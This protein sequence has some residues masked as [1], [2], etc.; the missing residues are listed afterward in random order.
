MH[1]YFNLRIRITLPIDLSILENPITVSF[2]KENTWLTLSFS[3]F[4]VSFNPWCDGDYTYFERRLLFLRMLAYENELS[5]LTQEK[6]TQMLSFGGR[7]VCC[8]VHHNM[9]YAIERVTEF[10]MVRHWKWRCQTNPLYLSSSNK[11]LILVV[12]PLVNSSPG[13]FLWWAIGSENRRW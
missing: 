7:I 6:E 10:A 12:D 8:T 9:S 2:D 1:F 11:F 13:S 4:D 3:I 5:T